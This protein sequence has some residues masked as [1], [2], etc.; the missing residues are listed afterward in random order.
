VDAIRLVAVTKYVGPE[1]AAGLVSL[2]LT[3]LGE[4][5]PQT[6]WEKA[7]LIPP[8]A[9]RWHLVGPLQRNKIRRTLPL[10]HLIHSV[11]SLRLIEAIDRIAA[12]L[13]QRVVDILL[14]VNVSGDANKQGLAPDAV[15]PLLDQALGFQ[16]V[17]I[18]G[19]MCM[20]G[21]ESTPDRTQREFALLRDLRDRLRPNY[22]GNVSLNELSMGMS[23]DFELAIAEGAT[24]VR[25]GSILFDRVA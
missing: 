20:G 25:L 16:S 10:V 17:R 12:E 22:G 3:D 4:S 23:D 5:R 11:D 8:G 18:R 24:I 6:L 9:V 7:E 15:G 1:I 13:Q 2:G 21:L 14:E 19:L